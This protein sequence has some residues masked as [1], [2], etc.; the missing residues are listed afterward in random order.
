MLDNLE[1]LD[2]ER[3]EKEEA[4]RQAVASAKGGNRDGSPDNDEIPRGSE[5][6][7]MA[8]TYRSAKSF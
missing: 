8:D 1:D 2:D 7:F 4:L 3:E 5:S 6:S